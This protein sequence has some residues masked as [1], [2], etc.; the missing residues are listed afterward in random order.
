MTIHK[1][2]KTTITATASPTDIFPEVSASYEL[3]VKTAQSGSSGTQPDA[4]PED[5]GKLNFSDVLSGAFYEDAVAW[6]VE[7]G[8]TKGTGDGATFSPND[9]CTRAQM[10]TF[11][12]PLFRKVIRE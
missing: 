4:K 9:L 3:T 7:N 1:A 6:A 8:I 2:G 5:D 11:L 12:L 10:V